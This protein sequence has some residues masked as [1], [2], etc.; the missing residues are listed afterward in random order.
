MHPF[1]PD[2]SN[3]N[4]DELLTKINELYSKMRMAMNNPP[5]YQQMCAIMDDYQLEQRLRLTKQKEELDNSELSKKIDIG[6]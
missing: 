1:T 5:V 2:L 6:K 3:L 4:D